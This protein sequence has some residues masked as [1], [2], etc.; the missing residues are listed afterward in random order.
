MSNAS[1]SI[2]QHQHAAGD[3]AHDAHAL[4]RVHHE[5]HPQQHVDAA[6]TLAGAQPRQPM[7]SLGQYGEC[8]YEFKAAYVCIPVYALSHTGQY[9][10]SQ[11][12]PCSGLGWLGNE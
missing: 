5:H 10:S 3:G 9:S 8:I 6:L 11:P 1:T 12:S 4:A 2:A 7:S